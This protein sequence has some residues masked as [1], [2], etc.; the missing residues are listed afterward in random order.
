MKKI[1]LCWLGL[2]AIMPLF[3]Q[4]ITAD[5]PLI[6]DWECSNQESDCEF[7]PTKEDWRPINKLF[8]KAGKNESM[9]GYYHYGNE[10]DPAE[11]YSI[12]VFF[13]AV[14]DGKVLSGEGLDMNE[15]KM[16]IE[17]KLS[18][19]KK[20]DILSIESY[21]YKADKNVITTFYRVKKN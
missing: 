12:M 16:L 14:Y 13:T 8:I 5:S 3:A 18:Y 2:T 11:G 19:D 10:Y 17:V 20:K 7:Y 6:G 1:F 15:E 21:H 4:Q 9:V